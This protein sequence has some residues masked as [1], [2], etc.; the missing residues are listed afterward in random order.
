MKCCNTAIQVRYLEQSSTYIIDQ[1]R[2]KV[3][4]TAIGITSYL[5]YIII[6]S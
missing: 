6:C 5:L 3:R 4:L 1:V 2:L